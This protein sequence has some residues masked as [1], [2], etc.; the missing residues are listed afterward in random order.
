[1]WPLTCGDA[2]EG[3]GGQVVDLLVQQGL[4]ALAVDLV[5]GGVGVDHPLH[6]PLELTVADELVPPQVSVGQEGR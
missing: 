1:M 3:L 4:W 6:Q 5:H 2:V